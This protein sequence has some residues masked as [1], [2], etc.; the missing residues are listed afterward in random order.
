MGVLDGAIEASVKNVVTA[1]PLMEIL[2]NNQRKLVYRAKELEEAEESKNIKVEVGRERIVREQILPRIRE[3]TTDEYG[4]EVA[5]VAIKQINYVRAVIPQIHDR[6]RSERIRIANRYESE[7]RKREA[8]I[9]GTMQKE[10][11]RI[12]SGGIKEATI[13]RGRAD[14]TVLNIYAEAYQKDPEFYTFLRT[15][16]LYSNSFGDRTRLVL[17]TR[18]NDLLRF[19]KDY[20]IA[21]ED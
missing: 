6:M 17:S 16:K 2:R 13:T 20:G 18:D 8:E 10:L 12:E 14:A 1:Q 7:G 4:L 11:D 5:G 21:G 3:K 15:L 19:L 9:L